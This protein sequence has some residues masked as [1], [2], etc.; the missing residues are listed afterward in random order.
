[1]MNFLKGIL[2]A[3]VQFFQGLAFL[4]REVWGFMRVRKR[5]WMAPFFV[6][7]LLFGLLIAFVQNA[8]VAQFIYTLF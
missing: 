1:M 4:I 5:Y 3:I 7:L 2:R 6:V 8:A